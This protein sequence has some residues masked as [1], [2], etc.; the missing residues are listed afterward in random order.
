MGVSSN[1][2][3]I[4]QLTNT[5]TFYE[6]LTKENTEIIEK[7]NLLKVYDGL[8][9]S[10]IN[11][12]T[13]SAGVS[14]VAVHD[15]I[16][17]DIT[18]GGDVSIDGTLNYDLG[19]SISSNFKYRIYGSTAAGYFP[20]P[21]GWTTEG[22]EGFTFGNAIG[23]GSSAG[24]S[25]V[26]VYKA[27]CDV[28]QTAD[29]VGLVSGI[30][31]DYID[32]T[33]LGKI[34]GSSLTNV[35][36][37]GI[38]AGCVYYLSGDTDGFMTVDQP[39]IK[40][41]VSKPMM[42]G[43]S[44]DAGFVLH[45]RGVVLAGSSGSSASA[46]NYLSAVIDLGTSSH[47]LDNGKVVGYGPEV[48]FNDDTLLNR[49]AYNDWFW[50]SSND[51]TAH[52]AV[53][54]VVNQITDQIIEIAIAGFVPEIITNDVGL[55]FLGSDGE[56]TTANNGENSKPI[57]VV[58]DSGGTK[59]GTILNQVSSPDVQSAQ[60]SASVRTQT[61]GSTGAVGSGGHNLLINGG[62]DVW[63]RGVGVSTA[64]TGTGS[65]Y[66]A[67]KWTRIDGV[68][69]SAGM[70][71]SIQRMG[72]TA[73]QTEV[74]GNP[75]YYA[76]TQHIIQGSTASDKLYI[77]NRVENVESFRNQD[78]VLS[79]YTRSG[80]T[81]STMGIILTQN[82]DG[83]TDSLDTMVTATGGIPIGNLWEKHAFSFRVPELTTTTSGSNFFAIGFDVSHNENVLDFSQV[84]LEYGYSATPFEPI[85]IHEELEKCSRYYQRSYSIDQETMSETMISDCIPDYNVIDFPI[86]QSRDYYHKFPV[87][88]RDDPTF[89][90]FSP[91][92]G[93]TGDG[94]NRTACKD[95][96]LTSGSV[97]Y[98]SQTRVSP[99]GLNS[100]ENASNKKGARIVVSN[101]AVVLDNVS[102]HYIADADLNGNL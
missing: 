65:V 21:G 85:T 75:S 62:F 78:L 34:Q 90:I 14:T 82:H 5:N 89:T 12:S 29:A 48:N 35:V 102:I 47:D 38:T 2:Y 19:G 44:A 51:D 27:K 10:G 83:S 74:E 43:L 23:F 64:Y 100:F 92:S 101:G 96:R 26:Y 95:V 25:N 49:S 4:P 81:G 6:W 68:T 73:G 7:L 55:L 77:Q 45:Y 99:I 80:V 70:T 58:W 15:T 67:D 3:Q 63:Q 53:G 50:C 87:E 71:A 18:F 39:T 33:P 1:D 98:N 60:Y 40:N 56:L 57:A 88:M 13:S 32:L 72:F 52:H 36:T 93:Q 94:F 76:R 42:I 61:S 86:S 37:G 84:K 17:H 22:A 59:V 31:T 16:P 54:V 66:F 28:E 69:S 97:G 8:S 79:F 46:N 20:G 41:H 30:T 91:K 11:L 24:Y 9:G